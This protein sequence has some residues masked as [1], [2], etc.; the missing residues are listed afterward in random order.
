[1]GYNVLLLLMDE[2]R[3]LCYTELFD[4]EAPIWHLTI[5]EGAPYPFF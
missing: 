3:F 5:R 1:M 4:A 2:V